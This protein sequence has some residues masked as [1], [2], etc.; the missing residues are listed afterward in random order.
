MN[1]S[2]NKGSVPCSATGCHGMAP[3]LNPIAD[4]QL[5]LVNTNRL[6]NDVIH[7]CA[8]EALTRLVLSVG[9]GKRRG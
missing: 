6:V 5:Q 3:Y 2:G 4:L 7:L 9:P 8:V 1:A